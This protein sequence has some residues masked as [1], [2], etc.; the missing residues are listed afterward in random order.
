MIYHVFSV[1]LYHVGWMD[2]GVQLLTRVQLCPR[3]DIL[4]NLYPYWSIHPDQPCCG[5]CRYQSV[6]K[7][8]SPEGVLKSGSDCIVLYWRTLQNSS[9]ITINRLLMIGASSWGIMKHVYRPLITAGFWKHQKPIEVPNLPALNPHKVQNYMVVVCALEDNFAEMEFL[10]EELSKITKEVYEWNSPVDDD[11]N[12]APGG[13]QLKSVIEENE[14]EE[15]GEDNAAP[16]R[17]KQR[18]SR[19]P[20][21]SPA[22]SGHM[23]SDSEDIETSKQPIRT[24]YLGHV[25]GYQPIRD[26]Y[27]LSRQWKRKR[28]SL[29]VAV[30]VVV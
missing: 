30:V 29:P 3:C 5:C 17:G 4:R 16:N 1:Y 21:S 18:V 24:P 20:P 22:T 14:E 12:P 6:D 9:I 10:K 28:Q 13:H 15:K 25:T 23:T 26:Q 11:E 7:S 2:R 8:L 27:F 19:V